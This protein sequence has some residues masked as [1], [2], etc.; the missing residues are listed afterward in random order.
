MKRANPFDVVAGILLALA[1]FL[2]LVMLTGCGSKREEVTT[3]KEV[4]K[5]SQVERTKVEEPAFA[6]DGAPY[7]K[8]TLT[9]RTLDEAT[10]GL[11]WREMSATTTLVPPPIGPI[12]AKTVETVGNAFVP[13]AGTAIGGIVSA[14]TIAWAAHKTAQANERGRRV[15]DLQ[16]ESNEGWKLAD[17]RALKL[18]PNGPK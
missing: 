12:V 18:P 6:P 5:K 3:H 9:T 17:E 13:G 7:I 14:L 11:G 15:T 2:L 8:V 10:E 1:A 4:A 16:A